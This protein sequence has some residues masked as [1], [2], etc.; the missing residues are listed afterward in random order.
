[1]ST[2]EILDKVTATL[3]EERLKQLLDFA[4]FL[5]LQEEQQE[6]HQSSQEHFAQAYGATE[7]DYSEADGTPESDA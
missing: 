1:M 4:R 2:R 6:W 3:P 7:P 5:S